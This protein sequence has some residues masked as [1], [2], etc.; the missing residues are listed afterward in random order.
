MRPTGPC[1][2]RFGGRIRPAPSASSPKAD[3]QAYPDTPD[4]I[5]NVSGYAGRFA[6]HIRLDSSM[7]MNP[8]P[9]ILIAGLT[10]ARKSGI[11]RM[12]ARWINAERLVE[13]SDV[14]RATA[15]DR[16]SLGSILQALD[17]F[18]ES[19]G[20]SALAASI[21]G[22]LP[23]ATKRQRPIIVVGLRS[24]S[25]LEY[26]K[27][28]EQKTFVIYVHSPASIRH[29][30]LRSDPTS[31]AKSDDDFLEL[32]R[33]GA[34]EGIETVALQADAI[35]INDHDYPV[36]LIHQL[37]ALFRRRD[38]GLDEYL[39]YPTHGEYMN[40][41]GYSIKKL[42]VFQ[43]DA[44]GAD[45]ISRIVKPKGELATISVTESRFIAYVDFPMDAKPRANHFHE[46]KL[47]HLYLA[48]GRVRLFIRQGGQKQ[49]PITEVV[50]EEGDLVTISP[51][52]A[53][54]YITEVPGFGIEF[55]P[56]EYS[57]IARDKVRDAVING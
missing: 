42:G 12:L 6:L 1:Q 4:R 11:G 35:I 26:F 23:A 53:H 33:R 39:N 28:H 40:P 16:S 7:H 57:I 48:R 56:T 14:F 34:R 49:S 3:V 13:L 27:T 51:G 20:K 47:E 21:H 2:R 45:P 29:D 43:D 9:L 17:E 8:P 41:K 46:E 36:P 10:K 18:R 15:T 31:L 24:I 55:S 22:I 54:A 25:D 38:L 44:E 5:L 19:R 52:F 37:S 50:V 30:R 32:D